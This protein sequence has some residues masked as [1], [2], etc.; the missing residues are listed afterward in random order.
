MIRDALPQPCTQTLT[1]RLT[2]PEGPGPA[3]RVAT[4]FV[5]IDHPRPAPLFAALVSIRNFFSAFDWSLAL[6]N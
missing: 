6:L 4:F 2:C 1:T 3:K 5:S